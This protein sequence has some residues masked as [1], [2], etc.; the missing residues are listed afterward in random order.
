MVQQPKSTPAMNVKQPKAIA[1]H[2]QATEVQQSE[3]TTAET[4][5]HPTMS[6]ATP[7]HGCSKRSRRW[8]RNAHIVQHREP[9]SWCD[10][11]DVPNL[12]VPAPDGAPTASW[13]ANAAGRSRRRRHRRRRCNPRARSSR[14]LHE[15][16]LLLAKSGNP[17]FQRD[18]ATESARDPMAL[19]MDAPSFVRI[20]ADLVLQ[21]QQ[22][23]LLRRFR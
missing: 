13:A 9:L 22:T 4:S 7:G 12:I 20:Y 18:T 6:P 23:A 10:P 15:G 2:G 21:A 16:L 5:S 8:G 11:A 14:A 17:I 3:A 19:F 1:M